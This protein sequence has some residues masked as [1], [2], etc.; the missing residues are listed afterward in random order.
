[1][2]LNKYVSLA[3]GISR[4][5]AD[6]EITMGKISINGH[7]SVNGQQ[8]NKSDRVLF[9]GKLL[10]IPDDFTTIMLNKPTHYVV[11][12]NGQGSQ[13]IYELLPK[14][15]SNLKPVGRL[16]KYSSGL[17]LLTNDGELAQFLTHP[18]NKK[19]KIYEVKLDNPL[20]KS[21]HRL[22]TSVGVELED[23]ISKLGLKRLN[24]IPNEIQINMSEGRN[25]QIRRTFEALGYEV[26]KLHRTEFGEYQLNGLR[27]GSFTLV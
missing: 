15:Y 3:T 5:Q 27:S 13:T 17:L 2:R 6:S 19:T 16:D 14:E 9:S 7:P 18:G 12:R 20:R 22:I 23:G 1:M 25:R 21:D 11:S 24:D 26:V 4:R 8:V 10:Q